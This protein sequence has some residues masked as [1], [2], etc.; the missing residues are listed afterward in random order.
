MEQIAEGTM[1][2]FADDFIARS[3]SA[4]PQFAMRFYTDRHLPVFDELAAKYLICDRWFASHP[5][6]DPAQSLLHR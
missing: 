5:R 1:R 2:G 6:R 3:P 4:N